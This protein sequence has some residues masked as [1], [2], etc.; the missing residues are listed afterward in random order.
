VLRLAEAGASVAAGDVNTDGLAS[1]EAEG[2]G[3]AGKVF[4]RKLD[5]SSEADVRARSSTWAND[6]MGGLNGLINNAGILRDGLLVKKDRKTGEVTKLSAEQWNAVLARQ[7]HRRH[8]HGARG[9]RQDGQDRHQ[10]GRH[11]QHVLDRA[12]R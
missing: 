1:L 2:Q 5:V 8:L 10:A 11:R 9:G 6:A 7:P 12:P 4:T 3:K